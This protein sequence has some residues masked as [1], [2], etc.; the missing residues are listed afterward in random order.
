MSFV[1]ILQ[2]HKGTKGLR[3]TYEK[4]MGLHFT[5]SQFCTFYDSQTSYSNEMALIYSKI[6]LYHPSEKHWIHLSY[7]WSNF[8]QSA[9]GDALGFWK[10]WCVFSFLE[11]WSCGVSKCLKWGDGYDFV[12]KYTRNISSYIDQTLSFELNVLRTTKGQETQ[13]YRYE[14]IRRL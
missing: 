1:V 14:G 11:R 2:V 3:P 7:F 8:Q 9:V 6:T 13:F 5:Y 4:I 10:I 12:S